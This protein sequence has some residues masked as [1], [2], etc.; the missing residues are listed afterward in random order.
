MQNAEALLL[1]HSERGRFLHLQYQEERRK[2]DLYMSG[3][4]ARSQPES[5]NGREQQNE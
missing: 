1:K 4:A 5:Q 3:L 2:T